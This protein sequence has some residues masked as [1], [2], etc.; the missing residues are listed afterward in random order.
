MKSNIH[1]Y[2][3]KYLAMSKISKIIFALAISSMITVTSCKEANTKTEITEENEQDKDAMNNQ[4]KVVGQEE[5]NVNGTSE[6]KVENSVT[7]EQSNVAT[8]IVKANK[9][10][11]YKFK[12]GQYEKLEYEWNADAPLRY[13][14]HGDPDDKDSYPQGYFESYANGTSNAA[15]GKVTIPY[16]GSHGWYWKNTS[17]KDITITLTT[18][19]NYNTIGVIQ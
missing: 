3:N 5:F 10:L 4:D 19:G 16:K 13:D 1:E 14:F 18:K 7:N 17:S 9:A 2:Q 8:I 6:N 15:K 11:E 12:I